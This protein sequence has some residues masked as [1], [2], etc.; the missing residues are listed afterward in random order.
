[1]TTRNRAV[2]ILTPLNWTPVIWAPLAAL[3]ALAGTASAQYVPPSTRSPA[4]STAIQP[5]NKQVGVTAFGLSA[6][7]RRQAK[8]MAAKAIAFL[9]SKQDA[10]GGWGIYPGAPKYPAITGL[11]L[12]GMLA[13]QTV[14]VSDPAITNAVSF[15][16]ANQREDGGIYDGVLPSYNTA[17]SVTGLSPLLAP[18]GD[19]KK[20]DPKVVEAVQKAVAFLKG[21]QYGE[22]AQAYKDLPEAA[23]NVPESDAFYG[24][25]GYGNRGRPDLSNTAFVLEALHA[26]GIDENDPA[27]K[28]AQTFIARCQMLESTRAGTVNDTEYAKGSKQGG[29]IYATSVNKDN[30][31]VGQSFA[32]ETVESLSG[33]PGAAASITLKSVLSK[34]TGPDGKE[35]EVSKPTTLSRTEI[36]AKIHKIW[37]RDPDT[38][39]GIAEQRFLVVLG[40]N[41]DGKSASTFEVR[42]GLTA[43]RLKAILVEAFEQDVEN[44]SKI[45]VNSVDQ[46]SGAVRL[47]AYGSMSYAGMKSYLYAGL[48]KS[49]PRVIAVTGWIQTNYTLE[50]N[51]GLG[52]DGQYYYYVMFARAMEALGRPTIWALDPA[53]RKVNEHRWAADLL[54][55]LATLQ[56]EDGSFKAVDDRWLENDPVLITAYSLVALQAAAK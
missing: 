12:Q 32:G 36:E 26:A 49:D 47:R 56:N 21:I 45:V 9:R 8:A 6:T 53:T 25:W 44:E 17:I 2:S 39:R 52:T 18:N 42:A 48:S 28:R 55:K 27:L 24:G 41:G 37:D 20:A 16:L 22:G 30:I 14:D 33:G 40:P 50:E 54:A 3:A 34:Q 4:P 46:W 19:A 38:G 31:G 43:E 1:M 10:S 23:Q 5:A 35:T 51:P 15:L 11:V 7:E 29:F 13:N